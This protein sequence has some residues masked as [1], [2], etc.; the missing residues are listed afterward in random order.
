MGVFDASTARD[1]II[2]EVIKN[3]FRGGFACLC[4]QTQSVLQVMAGSLNGNRSRSLSL[5]SP[6]RKRAEA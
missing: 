2:V 6:N 1:R 4:L 5:D 3:G